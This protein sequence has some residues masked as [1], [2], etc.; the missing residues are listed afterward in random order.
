[1]MLCTE[2]EKNPMYNQTS[3]LDYK[4]NKITS[5][6]LSSKLI[7]YKQFEKINCYYKFT[8]GSLAFIK[9]LAEISNHY[10]KR[11]IVDFCKIICTGM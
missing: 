11:Y 8:L 6:S 5:R 2:K 7:E 4:A 10:L 1:M 9:T 3:A